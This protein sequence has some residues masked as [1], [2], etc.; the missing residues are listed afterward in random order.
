MAKHI[1]PQKTVFA[2][3]ETFNMGGIINQALIEILITKQI[4][5]E[6]ELV[7]SIG[8]INRQQEYFIDGQ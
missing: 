7:N 4:I 3:Q 5:S 2:M 1:N 8:K 6:E